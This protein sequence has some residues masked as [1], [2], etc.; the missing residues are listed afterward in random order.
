MASGPVIFSHVEHN[1]PDFKCHV[2]KTWQRGKNQLKE[3]AAVSKI[4]DPALHTAQDQL[5][6]WDRRPAP[7]QLPVVMGTPLPFPHLSVVTHLS[8]HH[9]F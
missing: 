8:K 5:S 1:T 3:M 9:L 2:A 7:A 6:L 4:K